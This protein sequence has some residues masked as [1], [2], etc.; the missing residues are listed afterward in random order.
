M[1]GMVGAVH[2]GARGGGGGDGFPAPVM[3]SFN[4]FHSHNENLKPK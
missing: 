3:G 1:V 2:M 4:W